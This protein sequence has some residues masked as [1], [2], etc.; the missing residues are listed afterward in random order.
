MRKGTA[1]LLLSAIAWAWLFDVMYLTYAANLWPAIL[2]GF[3]RWRFIA[4]V[5]ATGTLF[6]VFGQPIIAGIGRLLA[7]GAERPDTTAGSSSNW[8]LAGVAVLLVF[9]GQILDALS[10]K[11]VEKAFWGLLVVLVLLAFQIGL[12]TLLWAKG[13]RHGLPLASIGGGLA[14]GFT[15]FVLQAASPFLLGVETV[16]VGSIL[17]MLVVGAAGG[18]VIDYGGSARPAQRLALTLLAFG[19]L[20]AIY[21]I[22]F[23]HQADWSFI[24]IPAGWALGILLYPPAATILRKGE[25]AV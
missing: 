21:P 2:S 10:G 22:L 23:G 4:G 14:G 3:A 16:D 24:V 9:I 20:G 5:I 13:A 1:R 7:P 17:R 12:V 6:M 18:L 19:I 25:L 15:E 8:Y 11:L